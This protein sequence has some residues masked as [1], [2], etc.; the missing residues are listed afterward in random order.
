MTELS[1]RRPVELIVVGGSEGSAGRFRRLGE[2]VGIRIVFRPR[3]PRFEQLQ[4]VY[5]EFRVDLGVVLLSEE[6]MG[7][8]SPSKFSGYI[9][10]GLPLLYVGPPE[11]NAAEV[12]VRF[13]GG[14]WLPSGSAPA[15]RAE[16]AESIYRPGAVHSAA[17]AALR[18]SDYFS[19][20]N[21][22]SLAA[23]LA[24]RLVR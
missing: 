3:V 2:Q 22:D 8:V 21:Q 18:D 16:V 6:S 10:F 4:D 15:A 14:F 12:C 11:T 19:G 24:P 17:K 7:V 13:G 9:D 5:N 20:F 1:H 23:L